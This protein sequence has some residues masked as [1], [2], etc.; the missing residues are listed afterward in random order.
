MSS[1]LI[2]E[3]DAHLRV[4]LGQLFTE[5][6]FSVE[7]ATNGMEALLA[8]SRGPTPGVIILDL[9]MPTLSGWEF[10][11]ELRAHPHT[12]RTLVVVVSAFE[13]PPHGARID[14]FNRKPFKSTELLALARELVAT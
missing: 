7:M 5:G 3:D 11:N 1:V 12:A 9:M 6:G 4:A 10:L 8:L 14:G 13:S 2:V